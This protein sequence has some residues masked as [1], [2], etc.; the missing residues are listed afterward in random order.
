MATHEHRNV[1]E[2]DEMAEAYQD[3]TLD[4]AKQPVE[5]SQV[6]AN[7][8]MTRKILLKLDIR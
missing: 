2:K 8:A 3:E 7:S 1:D 4:A 5:N 6:S